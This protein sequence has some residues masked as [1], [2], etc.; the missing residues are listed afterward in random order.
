MQVRAFEIGVPL[1]KIA[2]THRQTGDEKSKEEGNA[3]E[4]IQ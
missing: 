3:Q 2:T 1:S 4:S